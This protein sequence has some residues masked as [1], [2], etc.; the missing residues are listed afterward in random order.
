MTTTPDGGARRRVAS[1]PWPHGRTSRARVEV[2]IRTDANQG[3]RERHRATPRSES[4]V[5][6]RGDIEADLAYGQDA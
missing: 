3:P 6:T 2:W 4:V 5:I 1:L